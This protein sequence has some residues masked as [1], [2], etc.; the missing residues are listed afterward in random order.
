MCLFGSL[1][2]V[3]WVSCGYCGE[4]CGVVLGYDYSGVVVWCCIEDGLGFLGVPGCC[5]ASELWVCLEYVVY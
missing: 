3:V 5:P 2:W 1:C 4:D